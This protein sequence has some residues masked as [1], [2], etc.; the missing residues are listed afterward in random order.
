MATNFLIQ[1]NL[2]IST[3]DHMGP[4]LRAMFPDSEIAK[5]YGCG[6]T[7]ISAIMNKALGPHCHEYVVNHIRTHPFSLGIDGSSDTC[8]EKMNP[9]T[10]KIFDIN[11][12]K[13]VSSHFYNMCVTS[14]R[15]ASKAGSI[16]KAAQTKMEDDNIE[17]S[18]AVSLSVDNTNSMIGAHNSFACRCKD[19]NE[20]IY[21][22]GCPCHLAHIAASNANDAFVEISGINVEDLLID[23]Y[24]WFEKN[25]KRKGVLVEYL[26]FCDQEY[27]KI[28][29]HSSTRWRCVERCLK[30][31][32]GLKSYF[33]SENFAD[34][35][36][37]RLQ[38]AFEDSCTEAVL[39]F[40]HASIPVFTTFNKLLQSGEPLV[41]VVH[42]AVTKFARTLGNRVFKAS[43]MK[44]SPS[45][46]ID[47]SDSEVYIPFQSI[48][49]GSMT[50]STLQKLLREGDISERSY[51]NIFLA[52]QAYF[53]AAFLYVLKKFRINDELLQHAKW[54]DVAKRSKAEWENVEFFFTKFK[55]VTSISVVKQ[56]ALYDEFCDYIT[57]TDGEIGRNI[58]DDAKVVDGY[59][60]DSEEVFHYRMHIVWW[61]LAQMLLPES[62]TR[63]FKHLH[64]LAEAV[65][66]ISHSNAGEERLFSMVCKNKTDSRSAL[67]LEG[68]LSSLLSMKLHYSECSTPCYTWKPDEALLK[69]AK[70]AAR[71][72]NSEHK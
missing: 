16:F 34:A 12:P 11:G 24:Y 61:H 57:L 28:L 44:D 67:G 31:Y 68:T 53:K 4:L 13:T 46:D 10:V 60:E 69:K 33:L 6:R 14:G 38:K 70:G 19:Q 27:M 20:N 72:Y 2:P 3:S 15:D 41:H 26:E 48:Y 1:H 21:V 43:V 25:T 66:V 30:K 71:E 17:F 50:K 52:A 45:F 58:W 62:S 54:I 59:N 37:Q 64:K 32:A 8:V 51:N 65:L 7:K 22:L 49:L 5:N 55:A 23:L 29:K 42:D 36:F 47:A 35:R 18:Q 9:M 56:D 40:H 63:R 39:L